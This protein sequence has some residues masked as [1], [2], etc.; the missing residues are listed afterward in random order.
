MLKLFKLVES[1]ELGTFHPSTGGMSR[2]RWLDIGGEGGL[3]EMEKVEKKL[4]WF[5]IP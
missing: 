4:C 2:R 1:A 3:G 5:Y